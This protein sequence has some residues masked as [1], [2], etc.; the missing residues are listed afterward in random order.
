MN[1]IENKIRYDKI[2]ITLTKLLNND[3]SYL[4]LKELKFIENLVECKICKKLKQPKD[5][6]DIE[7]MCS[8]MCGFCGICINSSKKCL[9]CLSIT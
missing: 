9:K 5:I 3:V 7:Y 2:D 6:A 1:H 4:I 8:Y